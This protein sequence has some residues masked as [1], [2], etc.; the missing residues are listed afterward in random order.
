MIRSFSSGRFYGAEPKC[1]RVKEMHRLFFYLVYSYTGK[2]NGDQAS[3]K[4]ELLCNHPE[5]DESMLEQIPDLYQV[6]I[7]YIDLLINFQVL[8]VFL[9][10]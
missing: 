5:V 10:S 4:E 9:S 7:S 2:V 1:I 8:T 6:S 3:L